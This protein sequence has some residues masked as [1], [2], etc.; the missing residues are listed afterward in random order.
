[1]QKQT[2]SPELL[3]G[4]VGLLRPY[5]PELSAETLVQSLK[6]T[7]NKKHIHPTEELLSKKQFAIKRGCSEM[8]IHRLIQ[9]GKIPSIRISK[10]L[11]KIPSSALTIDM[12]E[13]K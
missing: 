5:Y 11:I 12:Q 8:T 13:V 3:A 9:T 7:A 1:M 2:I 4:A 6:E 10:R